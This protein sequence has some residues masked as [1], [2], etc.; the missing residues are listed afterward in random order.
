MRSLIARLL[1]GLIWVLTLP[2]LWLLYLP[3]HPVAWILDRIIRY[4]RKVII[5]NIQG[6]FPELSGKDLSLFIRR[7]YRWLFRVT[8]ESVKATHWSVQRLAKQIHIVNPE[9]LAESSAQKQDLIVLAGHTGNWEWLPGAISPL[10]FDLLGVF[11]PQSNQLFNQLTIWLRQKKQVIPIPMK[12]T[13]RALNEDPASARPRALLL[14]G[15]QIPAL[16]DIHFWHPFLNRETAWFTGAEKI[17]EKKD[18]PVYYIRMTPGLKGHYQAEFIPLRYPGQDNLPGEITQ[19]YIHALEQTIQEHP[20]NWLW[21][22]RRWK[23]Q[24]ENVS[25]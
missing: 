24:R 12:A 5:L 3:E 20:V 15:D 4:R 25:L 16:G 23:H 17:A 22:H 10:G 7:Y 19:Y 11:K 1:Y 6:S 21:S 9:V 2:P 18:L 8:V 13:L 14:I